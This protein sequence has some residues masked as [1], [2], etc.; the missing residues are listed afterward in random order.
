MPQSSRLCNSV[1]ELVGATPL[2]RLA[3]VCEPGQAS[4]LAK[5]EQFNPSGSHKDRVAQVIIERAEAAGLLPPG[6]TVVEASCGSFAVALAL[7]CRA[8][9]Y[10][11]LAVLP[12]TVTHEHADVLAAYGASLELTPAAQG[13][14]GAAARAAE[15]AAESGFFSPRQYDNP[16]NWQ[17]HETGEGAELAA[18]ARHYGAAIDAFVMTLG[19]GGTLRGVQQ[20]L[21]SAFPAAM[22]VAIS[23]GQG[24]G[25]ADLPLRC[26]GSEGF[27]KADRTLEV[28]PD[29]AWRMKDRLAREEGLLVGPTSGAN[30]AGALRIA[31]ELGPGK[32]VYTLCCDTGERY[33]SLGGRFG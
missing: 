4:V 9:G 8:R 16:Q 12:E 25:T 20:A 14:L 2:V 7:V 3:R 24:G 27:F 33:F 19:T 5:L 11:L 21:R 29:A 15:I 17:A 22:L 31:R 23:L 6:Q 26:S 18:E 1:L 13:M 10:R 30:V 28:S 32:F